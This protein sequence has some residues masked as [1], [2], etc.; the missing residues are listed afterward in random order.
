MLTLELRCP[1]C[2]SAHSVTAPEAGVRAWQ[3]GEL[4]QHALPTLSPAEREQLISRICPKCQE[5]I[6]GADDEDDYPDNCD[7]DCGYDPYAGCYT[8]DC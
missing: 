4:I 5:D 6:F 3:G 8:D 1:F 2:G 7:D